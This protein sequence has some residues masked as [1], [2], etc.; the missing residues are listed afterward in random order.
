MTDLGMPDMS[1]WEV[2]GQIRANSPGVPVVLVTGWGT[3][4]GED[5]VE[6]AGIAAVVHKPFELRDLLDTTQR[7]LAARVLSTRVRPVPD[8][9][10]PLSAVRDRLCIILS[11]DGR[12]QR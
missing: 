2:A 8:P 7:V 1:G 3:T 4:I 6:A 9:P 12:D 5:E 11:A 10:L